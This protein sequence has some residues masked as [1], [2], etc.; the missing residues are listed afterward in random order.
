MNA[1]GYELAASG[2]A[3]GVIIAFVGGLIIAGALIW[4]VRF[5]IKVRR[6]EPG[7]PTPAEQPT[8]PQSGAVYETR[9]AREPDE[10]PQAGQEG[11]RLRPNNMHAAGSKTAEDQPRPRWES[12]SSGSFG[13]GG[14]GST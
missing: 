11:E 6:R 4:A 5:G 9:E 7:P 13:S 3:V 8:L 10:V 2:A 14:P 12:G 1:T